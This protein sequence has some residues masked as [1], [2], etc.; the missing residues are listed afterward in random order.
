MTHTT[1]SAIR[2]SSSRHNA[3]EL[4]RIAFYGSSLLSSYWN[5]AATYYRGMTKA[6][7]GLGYRTTFYESD[8]F[9]RQQHRDI[10]PPDWCDV[11]VY[12]A[13]PAAMA[14]AAADARDAEI[15]VKVFQRE[16]KI[17]ARRDLKR[18]KQLLETGEIAT[19]RVR[20]APPVHQS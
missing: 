6:L 12:R 2:R 11:V 17:Q 5:G 1:R 10:E 15:V 7:S 16:P 4:I 8:A 3:R 19:A 14:E 9:D 13:S 20:P 18:F